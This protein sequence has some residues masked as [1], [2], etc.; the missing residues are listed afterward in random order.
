MSVVGD[1][2]ASLMECRLPPFHQRVGAYASRLMAYNAMHT[3]LAETHANDT[4]RMS[5]EHGS[6]NASQSSKSW[7]FL[8]S[9]S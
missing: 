7:A 3:S 9:S 1:K 4:C 6:H 8:L 5:L 2:A